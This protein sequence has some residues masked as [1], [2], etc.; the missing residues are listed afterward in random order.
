MLRGCGSGK[1]KLLGLAAQ[2]NAGNHRRDYGTD[3]HTETCFSRQFGILICKRGN[4]ERYGKADATC[5]GRGEHVAHTQS[6]SHFQSGHMRGKPCRDHNAQ[7]LADHQSHHNGNDDRRNEQ[8]QRQRFKMHTSG[9]Q[10]ENRQSQQRGKRLQLVRIAFGAWGFLSETLMSRRE[11]SNK[12]AS[13]SRMHTGFEHHHPSQNADNGHG[14]P[15]HFAHTHQEIPYDSAYGD[16]DEPVPC[17]H[18]REEHRDQNNGQQIVHCGKR[19]QERANRARQRFGEQSKHSQR[20]RDISG[21]RN[22]PTMRHLTKGE[23]RSRS[24]GQRIGSETGEQEQYQQEQHRRSH[25]TAHSAQHRHCSSL[26]VRQRTCGEFLFQFQSDSQEEHR[27]QTILHPVSQSHIDIGVGNGDAEILQLFERMRRE[28]QIGK[29]QT[30]EGEA[31]HNQT[32]YAVGSGYVSYF[33]PESLLTFGHCSPVCCREYPRPAIHLRKASAVL[34]CADA[35]IAV[36]V[37]REV[38]AFMFSN[39]LFHWC[40]RFYSAWRLFLYH[41]VRS[42]RNRTYLDNSRF[43]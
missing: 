25:H 9:E 11:Q 40:L 12:H 21:R 2:Q 30:C 36:P 18:R 19:H 17:V 34:A 24:D 29:Q 10:G 1:L 38:S 7:R 4:Q 28:R 43:T 3:Q 13:Q 27:Q 8:G 33:R 16:A 41:T 39:R 5:A 42:E 22:R 15:W 32:R 37:Y 20:E 23:T 31:K 26:G 35:S 14:K 6:L